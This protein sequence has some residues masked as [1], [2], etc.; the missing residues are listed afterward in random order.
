MDL[1][2]LTGKFEDLAPTHEM[3][4]AHGLTVYTFDH[5][6]YK[7]VHMHV[8][9]DGHEMREQMAGK[10]GEEEKGAN[11]RLN[12]GNATPLTAVSQPVK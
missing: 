10:K 2:S 3:I 8:I 7:V 6:T 5:P 1:W 12:I 9:H 4:K 11:A